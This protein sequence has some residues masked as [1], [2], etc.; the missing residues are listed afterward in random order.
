MPTSTLAN[1]ENPLLC[2]SK[3]DSEEGQADLAKF[4]NRLTPM[5]KR[6][7]REMLIRKEKKFPMKQTLLLDAFQENLNRPELIINLFRLNL[8]VN[9]W[10]FN[11][12]F[13]NQ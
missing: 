7:V 10:K 6:Q 3:A 11:C 8:N 13:Y 2:N 9:A 4:Q 1:G 5:S 12:I